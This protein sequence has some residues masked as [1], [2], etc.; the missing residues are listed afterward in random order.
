ML[1]DGSSFENAKNQVYY[2]NP[3]EQHA[4]CHNNP[5]DYHGDTNVFGGLDGDCTR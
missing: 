5:E 3:W 2:S 4:Y 1:L